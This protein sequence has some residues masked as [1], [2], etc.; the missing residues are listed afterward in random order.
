MEKWGLENGEWKMEN[1][2]RQA[3]DPQLK[4]KE[5]PDPTFDPGPEQTS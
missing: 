4:A 3:C 2:R 1:V 5:E